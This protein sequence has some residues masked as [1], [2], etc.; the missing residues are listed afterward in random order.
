ME[1]VISNL[2]P[3]LDDIK[4]EEKRNQVYDFIQINAPG[5]WTRYY[6]PSKF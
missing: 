6:R 3:R 2:L 4:L 5:P 1:L